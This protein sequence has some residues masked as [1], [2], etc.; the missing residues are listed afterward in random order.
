MVHRVLVTFALALVAGL[1][2]Q[3]LLVYPGGASP[4]QCTSGTCRGN[5]IP[6]SSSFANDYCFQMHIDASTLPNAP[7]VLTDMAFSFTGSGVRTFDNLMVSIGHDTPTG[8]NCS[9]FASSSPDFQLQF[10]GAHSFP[11]TAGAWSSFGLP[12]AF[13][14]DGVRGIVI[15]FRF[16]GGM[17]G[18]P[19]N[20]ADP[21]DGIS[22]AY[23]RVAGGFTATSCSHSVG[24]IGPKICL[25]FGPGGPPP[26]TAMPYG[27]GCGTPPVT[28][29]ANGLP[30]L[31]NFTFFLDLANA[32]AN[33]PAQLFVALGAGAAPTPLGGGCDLFLD[34][35][36]VLTFLSQGINPW[37]TL[38]TGPAGSVAFSLPVP[39]DPA[40]AGLRID[41]QAAVSDAGAPAG[42]VVSNAI[43]L[44]LN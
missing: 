17:G 4:T 24:T 26:A 19:V 28:L 36:D 20:Y 18:G 25:S 41:F 44:T 29:S 16:Q 14:Y 9:N 34:L 27:T 39:G 35:Q 40:L 6:F 12:L 21:G 11:Y 1:P 32:P 2:A 33:S 37:A 38:P 10:S 30:T 15:E 8:L 3:S 7:A 42:F 23:N 5:S 22:R 43:A 31:G 13:A